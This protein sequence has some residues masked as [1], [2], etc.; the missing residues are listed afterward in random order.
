MSERNKGRDGMNAEE[1]NGKKTR[2]GGKIQR[3][4]KDRIR[5]KREKTKRGKR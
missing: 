3:R 1:G 4:T 5:N 2:R